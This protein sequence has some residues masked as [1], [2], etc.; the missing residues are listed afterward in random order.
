M[1]A[2]KGD[3]LL[4]SGCGKQAAIASQGLL[5]AIPDLGKQA[6]AR[7]NNFYFDDETADIN[8]GVG[9]EKNVEESDIDKV[10]ENV[11]VMDDDIVGENSVIVPKVG[12]KFNDEN[13]IFEFY[14]RYAYLVGFPIRKRNSRKGDG[15]IV[16]YVTLTCSREGRRSSTTSTSLKPQPTSQTGCKARLTA[17]SEISGLW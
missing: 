3:Y 15:G 5:A 14:K 13:E 4:Q 17:G 10:R 11:N 9:D 7:N 12:M 8:V 16:R 1:A 2:P 6:T